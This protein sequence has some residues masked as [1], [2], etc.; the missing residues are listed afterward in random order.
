[1]RTGLTRLGWM[2]CVA[3]LLACGPGEDAASVPTAEAQRADIERTVMATGTIEPEGEVA[4][5]PRIA[6]I[7]EDILVEAG[8]QV[9]KGDVLVEIEKDLI[10]ARVKEAQAGV[11]AAKVE[12]RYADIDVNRAAQLQLRGASSDSQHDEARAAHE[13][14]LARLAR[15]DAVLETLSVQ[16]RYATIRSPMA[17]KVLH[18]PVE[19]GAAVS[20]VTS[21]TGGTEL[22]SLAEADR[23]HLEGSVDENEISQV[24]LGQLARVRTEA[25]GD[26]S[27]EGVVRD[28]APVGT[29]IQNVTYFEVEVEITDAEAE[30]LRPRMSGDAEIVTESIADA[31][32]IPETALRY[33]GDRVFVELSE[34][35]SEANA[36]ERQ[37]NIRVGVVDGDRV[38][39][40]EGLEPGEG[41]TLQ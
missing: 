26:R 8:Q 23:L 1:M 12:V 22:L 20:P 2:I 38:E 3:A 25:F 7:I 18:V 24:K 28:I 21:V 19:V 17:G 14:A 33:E 5:R 35:A 27:F 41:V 31:I 30:L 15:A 4:V 13:L 32:V 36:E 29:R 34:S 40:L 6:G 16:L 37:R 9:S 39:I 10:I 11:R